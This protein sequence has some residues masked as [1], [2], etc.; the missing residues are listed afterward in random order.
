MFKSRI[1]D[2]QHT[3][4]SSCDPKDFIKHFSNNT[5]VSP[6]KSAPGFIAEI[7]SEVIDLLPDDME[8]DSNHDV[9]EID[10]DSDEVS[11][12]FGDP[13]HTLESTCHKQ[14][15]TANSLN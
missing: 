2:N 10:L 7:V 6:S 13:L 9:S 15:T 8:T 11:N 14:L 5:P 3:S 1:F 4:F 12:D